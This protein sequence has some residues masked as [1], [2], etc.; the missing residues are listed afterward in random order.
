M[1]NIAYRFGRLIRAHRQSRGL[2]QEALADL[3]ALSR[4]YLGKVEL[5]MA[6][7]SL[8]TAHKIAK[9]LG[10]NLSS[11]LLRCEECA[12]EQERTDST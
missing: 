12:D 2:S 1:P 6:V 7:P 3:A 9:A 4:G 5:G 8:E 11:L 10:E